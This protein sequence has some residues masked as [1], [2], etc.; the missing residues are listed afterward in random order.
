MAIK[1]CFSRKVLEREDFLELSPIARLLYVYLNLQSDDDGL[2]GGVNTAMFFAGASRDELQQLLDSGYIFQAGK[3][4]VIRDFWL[5]N[6]MR[7]DRHKPTQYNKELALIQRNKDRT[8]SLRPVSEMATISMSNGNQTATKQQSVESNDKG[9]P[10][11]D[12]AITL[13]AKYLQRP[14][15][16]T[17]QEEIKTLVEQYGQRFYTAVQGELDGYKQYP[18]LRPKEPLDTDSLRR[19]LAHYHN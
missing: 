11:D 4:Y 10:I 5:N 8:L 3:V 15:Q 16:P 9:Q 19:L 1:R 6:T 18:E 13:A 17:E 12:T 7:T 2:V 14:L